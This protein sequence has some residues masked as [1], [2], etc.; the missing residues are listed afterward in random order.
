MADHLGHHEPAVIGAG[1]SRAGGKHS[2]A[3]SRPMGAF[4]KSDGPKKPPRLST[5]CVFLNESR[6][7]EFVDFRLAADH[8]DNNQPPDF[9]VVFGYTS[10]A[11][12][13][14]GFVSSGAAGPMPKKSVWIGLRFLPGKARPGLRARVTR[15]WAAA[16]SPGRP[17]RLSSPQILGHIP[18]YG[19]GGVGTQINGQ[20]IDLSLLVQF[21]DPQALHRISVGIAVE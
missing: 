10:K 19:H 21:L 17:T 11:P 1:L 14:I 3:G 16:S 4:D 12:C 5:F 7:R 6:D 20:I 15:T 13:C 9:E 8:S 2:F 18:E